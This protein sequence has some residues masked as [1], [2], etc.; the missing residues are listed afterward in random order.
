MATVAIIGSKGIP[1][2]YGGFET[3]AENLVKHLSDK[4]DFIVYCSA[5]AYPSRRSTYLG[6][7]L[8]Y[9]PLNANGVQSIP[10][11]IWSMIHASRR[12]DVLLILGVSGCIFLPVLK[13]FS[14][15]SV[16]VHLDGI[17]WKRPKWGWLARNFL[18]LSE[19]IAAKFADSL[20]ADNTGIEEYIAEHYKKASV[21]IA[22]GGDNAVSD[23]PVK[24]ENDLSVV[25]LH[26]TSL[27]M[28]ESQLTAGAN[29]Y[30]VAVCRIEPENNV[31]VILDA[32][33]K[34]KSLSLV[35]VGNWAANDYGRKLREEYGNVTNIR[36]VDPIYQPEKLFNVRSNALLYVHGHSAG[37]TNPSLVEAMFQGLPIMAYDVIFNRATTHDKA[38][39]FRNTEELVSHLQNIEPAQLEKISEDMLEI[40]RGHYTWSIICDDYHNL[41]E[42]SAGATAAVQTTKPEPLQDPKIDAGSTD[43]D[44]R[45][46]RSGQSLDS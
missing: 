9:L 41:F 19:L 30:V 46:A 5:E 26:K 7:S 45:E 23:L 37:G 29:E 39:Y 16:I 8:V 38:I 35:F 33:R 24:S 36:L 3:L 34:L 20:I 28:G 21:L 25:S 14:K 31:H 10:Y 15:K 18:R 42:R 40:S 27:E 44:P 11:D 13:L 4:H 1:A 32:F 43:G 17:D 12:A 6:A 22:Y 2:R